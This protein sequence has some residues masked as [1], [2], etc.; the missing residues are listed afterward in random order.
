MSATIKAKGRFYR[1]HQRL[2]C[3]F[4]NTHNPTRVPAGFGKSKNKPKLLYLRTT[5]T[6]PEFYAAD[7][8]MTANLLL[9]RLNIARQRQLLRPTLSQRFACV[10]FRVGHKTIQRPVSSKISPLRE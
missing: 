3:P 7:Y 9:R 6:P 2:L 1:R 4:S 5:T 8:A 10:L